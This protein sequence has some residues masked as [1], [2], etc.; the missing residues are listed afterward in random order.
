MK[1]IWTWVSVIGF[2]II[3]GGMYLLVNLEIQN[4]KKLDGLSEIL[5]S[6]TVLQD[7]YQG[8]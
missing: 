8:K 5:G 6:A 7:P 3:L 1:H 2:L 4:G